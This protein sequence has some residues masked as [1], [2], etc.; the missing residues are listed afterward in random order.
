[1]KRVV[2][3]DFF[4]DMGDLG[5]QTPKILADVTSDGRVI[6]LSVQVKI[7]CRIQDVCEPVMDVLPMITLDARK[8]MLDWIRGKT[9]CLELVSDHVEPWDDHDPKGAA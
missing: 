3:D 2:I 7:K 5:G 1:M 8:E 9:I 4:L 6:L